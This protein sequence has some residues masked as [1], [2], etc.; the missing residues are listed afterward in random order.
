LTGVEAFCKLDLWHVGSITSL[1]LGCEMNVENKKSVQNGTAG[2]NPKMTDPPSVAHSRP[3]DLVAL[4]RVAAAI[5]G[6]IDLEAILHVG[7][8]TALAILD[9]AIGGI[10]LLDED[11]ETLSYRVYHGI[12]DEYAQEMHLKLGEGVEGKVAENAR[13]IMVEDISKEPGTA[14]PDII[15]KEGLKAFVSV[16]LMSKDKVLGV[17]NVASRLSHQFTDRDIHV[18]HSIGDLLGLAIEQ[19]ILYEQLRKGRERYKQLARFAVMAQEEERK[20]LSREL[21]DETSQALSGL[22]LNLQAVIEMVEMAGVQDVR[23]KEIL[24]K[25]HELAIHISSEIH[26]LIVNLRPTLLDSLGLIPALRQ[27]AESTLVPMGI[28][29]SFQ[30]DDLERTLP[31]EVETGLFRV[32]QGGIGNIQQHSKATSASISLT[33]NGDDLVLRI[34]DNGVGFD[35]S[36]IRGIEVGGRGAGLF[37]IKERVKLMGGS[38]I[39]QSEPGKGTTA[40]AIIPIRWSTTHAEDKSVSS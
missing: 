38:C 18:L 37:S 39:I 32:A 11:T 34:S 31:R 40:T 28:D 23:I 10:M 20:R 13:S 24:K 22:T 1:V 26:R 29:V 33:V 6:F 2:I 9:S 12:S 27:H 21:H 17:M 14:H 30:F 4:S 25:A 5:S 8:D 19:A 15:S 36:Q 16:P 3:D 35:V 7:L